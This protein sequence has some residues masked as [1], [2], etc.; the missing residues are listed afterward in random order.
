MANEV[1]RLKSI[2]L[3]R[4]RWGEAQLRKRAK[5]SPRAYKRGFELKAFSDS[6]STFPSFGKC[7][8]PG[9]VLGD[10]QRKN[11]PCV[12]GVDPAG[13]KRLGNAIVAVKV[14]PVTR[15][16]F[17]VEVR[18]GAWRSSETADHIEDMNRA[19]N[20][21]VIMVENN[22]YQ[23]ALIDW[24]GD[25]KGRYSYWMK[26]EAVTTTDGLKADAELGL[27][28]L[29]VEFAHEAWC[30]PKSEYEGA[31]QDDED[32]KRAAWARLAY[33]F[34]YHPIA[35]TSD[36]VMATWFARQG[37]EMYAGLILGG[38]DAAGDFSDLNAR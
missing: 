38:M 19:H 31:G 1:V 2:P 20:P 22:A 27:P 28:G 29:E 4:P 32:P 24:V 14:D 35:S 8:I 23:Q 10:V 9:L 11:W 34:R 33:E 17:P 26:L 6:E 36:G 21:T 3:W 12:L 7:E 13:K 25:S 5:E 37:I 30:F 18:Y 16:R 15:R